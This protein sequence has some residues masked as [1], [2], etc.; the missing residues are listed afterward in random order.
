MWDLPSGV[1]RRRGKETLQ[2]LST[3][4]NP[5]WTPTNNDLMVSVLLQGPWKVGEGT[6]LSS[7]PYDR[8]AWSPRAGEERSLDNDRVTETTQRPPSLCLLTFVGETVISSL[9]NNKCHVHVFLTVP[10][11]NEG[12]NEQDEVYR[13]L[14][15]L[16]MSIV[17]HICFEEHLNTGWSE[18]QNP[19]H[20]D[21]MKQSSGAS[22]YFAW[23]TYF[24][25]Y[26]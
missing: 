25:M 11:T 15:W 24:Y 21:W 13:L 1:L 8:R 2:M 26:R 3:W 16:C 12:M 10:T 7:N 4:N 9:C 6:R 22:I 5:V 20:S 14:I 23:G 18:G 19:C 17:V